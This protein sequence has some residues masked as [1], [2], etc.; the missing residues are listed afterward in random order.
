M[1]KTTAMMM[2]WFLREPQRNKHSRGQ[3]DFDAYLLSSSLKRIRARGKERE[4]DEENC[5]MKNYKM[6]I[7][8]R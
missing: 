1:T 5:A 8:I 6:T 4:E 3:V 7:R 2:K